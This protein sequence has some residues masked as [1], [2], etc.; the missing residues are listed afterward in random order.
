MTPA[1]EGYMIAGYTVA[2]VIYL[3]YTLLLMRRRRELARRWPGESTRAPHP[4]APTPPD[5]AA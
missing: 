3:G 2:A 5:A 4:A 1:N